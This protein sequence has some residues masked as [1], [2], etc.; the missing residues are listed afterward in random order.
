MTPSWGLVR[1]SFELVRQNWEIIAYLFLLPA[2]LYTLGTVLLGSPGHAHSIA[3]LTS[4]QKL[5]LVSIGL[6][7]LWSFINSAASFYFR[8]QVGAGHEVT[9]GACYR[10]SWKCFW[11][12]WGVNILVGLTVL[13]G[14]IMLIIPGLIFL[15]RYYLSVYYVV[16][17]DVGIIAAMRR[18]AHDSAPVSGAIWGILG[19]LIVFSVITSICAVLPVGGLVVGQLIGYIVLFLPAL[20]HQE[21]VAAVP[22]D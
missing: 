20:R 9:L 4:K 2:L 13:V 18:S 14:L 16:S 1:P 19:V 15:R 21:I 6:G 3:E 11:R 12:V 7:G 10:H 22:E 8:S 17:E 5:G